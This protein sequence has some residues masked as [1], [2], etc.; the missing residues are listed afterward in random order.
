MEVTNKATQW[1]SIDERMKRGLRVLDQVENSKLRLL[2]NR[3]CQSLKSGA[4]ENIFNVEEEE[5][6]LVS[7]S[8][9]KVD[10]DILLQVLTSILTEAAFHS[11]KSTIMENTMKNDF[12]IGDDK[13]AI[14]SHCW[15]TH[16]EEIMDSFRQKSIFPCQMTDVSW[17][18]DVKAASTAMAKE[19]KP[20]A[21]IQLNLEGSEKSRLTVEMD[22]TELSDLYNKLNDIQAQLLLLQKEK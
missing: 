9:E 5:K 20:V 16:G 11:V 2:V 4:S 19:A 15:I 22:R 10:L 7:L 3:I 12:S 1:I 21:K 13:V 18:V 17:R 6:L 14:L 8:L